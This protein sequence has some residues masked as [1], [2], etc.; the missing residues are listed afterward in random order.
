LRARIG[1]ATGG[2]EIVRVEGMEP[3][4]KLDPSPLPHVHPE[5]SLGPK[6]PAS[7]RKGA[8]MDPKSFVGIDVA[9]DTLDVHILPTHDRF[10]Y[11]TQPDDVETLLAQLQKLGPTLITLEATGGYGTIL[12]AQLQGAGLRAAVVNPR[13]VRNFARAT[14]RLAKT[15]RIDAEILARFAEAIRPPARSVGSHRERSIKALVARRRQLVRMQTAEQ[16]RLY[17]AQEDPIA[18]SIQEILGL[19]ARQLQDIDRQLNDAIQASDCWLEK[20]TLIE[21]T[22]G[23]G[24]TTALNLVATLPELGH[25]NR[26]QIASLVGLAPMNRDSGKMRGYRSIRGGRREV[27]AA[28]YMPTLTAI[29]HNPDIRRF[30][31]RLIENGKKPTVAIT[32]CMRKMLI[33]LNA[34]ARNNQPWESQYA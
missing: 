26:R 3:V 25:L 27:R 1:P 33:T 10:E 4:T 21:S 8:R 6:E 30:Y 9:K 29:R 20:A 5:Q 7:A 15:D 13:Q 22:P 28:L 23:I 19:I 17:R 11:T 14:G 34:M 24:R 32:A 31:L 16:N 2:E 12:A 18:D